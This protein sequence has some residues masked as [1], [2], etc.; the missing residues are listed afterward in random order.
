MECAICFEPNDLIKYKHDSI[1]F[2]IYVHD[3][4]LMNWF[5]MNNFECIICRK[6]IFN[7]N[8]FLNNDFRYN[9]LY[10]SDVENQIYIPRINIDHVNRERQ[11]NFKTVLYVLIVI[12]IISIIITIIA[13]SV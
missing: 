5:F 3:S 2:G 6:S 13:S 4:C 1:C 7:E 8:R 12:C 9:Q 11:C 10:L